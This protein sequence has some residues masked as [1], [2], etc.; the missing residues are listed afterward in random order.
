MLSSPVE[1]IL[2]SG[3]NGYNTE[4]QRKRRHVQAPHAK[5]RHAACRG[6]RVTCDSILLVHTYVLV[7]P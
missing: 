2:H 5:G 4:I 7:S 6:G 3:V 1:D